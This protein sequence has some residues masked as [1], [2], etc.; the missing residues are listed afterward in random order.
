MGDT[1]KYLDPSAIPVVKDENNQKIITVD[2]DPD[3]QYPEEISY[4]VREFTEAYS[5]GDIIL[6]VSNNSGKSQ[7]TYSTDAIYF[8]ITIHDSWGDGLNDAGF[9]INGVTITGEGLNNSGGYFGPYV[10]VIN[11]PDSTTMYSE[12]IHQNLAGQNLAGQNLSGVN[13]TGIT[14]TEADLSGADLSGAKL[15]NADLNGANL[16]THSLLSSWYTCTNRS[17]GNRD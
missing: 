13:L 6:N 16:I 14:L 11:D 17:R 10:F 7:T 9:K 4:E 12:Y 15:S 8:K 5:G 2:I 3:G 1:I